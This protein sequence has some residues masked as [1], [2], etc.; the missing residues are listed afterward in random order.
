MAGSSSRYGSFQ[1][2][3]I[4]DWFLLQRSPFQPP[5]FPFEPPGFPFEP[6]GFPSE[7]PGSPRPWSPPLSMW[8]LLRLHRR[9]R[10][11]DDAAVSAVRVVSAEA[12]GVAEVDTSATVQYLVDGVVSLLRRLRHGGVTRGD[13][14]EHGP[15]G[16]CRCRRPTIWLTPA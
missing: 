10:P 2:R 5:G 7:S 4:L 15:S 8:L 12:S 3:R 9:S 1:S 6:P 11:P 13:R 14:L 16:P